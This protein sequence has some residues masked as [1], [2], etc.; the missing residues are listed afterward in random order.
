M[1]EFVVK[2]PVGTGTSDQPTP[3][4]FQQIVT[5]TYQLQYPMPKISDP[6]I[7][8]WTSVPEIMEISKVNQFFIKH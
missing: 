2:E 7:S 5:A 1:K 6:A 3:I 4:V 8:K